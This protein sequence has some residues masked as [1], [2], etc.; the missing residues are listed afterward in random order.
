VPAPAPP[1]VSA[2]THRTEEWWTR[3]LVRWAGPPVL[4]A[5]AY[6]AHVIDPEAGDLPLRCPF[7][8]VTGLYCPGCGVSRALHRLA[9]G[10]PLGAISFNVMAMAALA[11][12][13][14]WVASAMLTSAGLRREPIRLPGRV[15][16]ALPWVVIAFWVGRNIPLAPFT[17]LAP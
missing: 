15:V 7:L 6:A 5:A 12:G 10:D 3:P 9:I 4:A 11:V 16:V 13:I 2:P 14:V 1:A 8:A 17:L